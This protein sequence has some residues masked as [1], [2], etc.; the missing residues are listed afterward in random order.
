MLL[1]CFILICALALVLFINFISLKSN[2]AALLKDKNLL[3]NTKNECEKK[4]EEI[5][6]LY[7]SVKIENDEIKNRYAKVLDIDNEVEKQKERYK[8]V[9]QNVKEIEKL[10][11]DKYSIYKKLINEIEIYNDDLEMISV[12]LYKPVFN[13][14]TSGRYKI[15]LEENYQK[16][17]KLIKNNAAV[18]CSQRFEI[19]GSYQK[20]NK[21][22]QRYKKLMLKAFNGLCDSAISSLKWNNLKQIEARIEKAYK[23]VNSLGFENLMTI[24]QKFYNLKI[25]EM[26]LMYEF[27]QKKYEEKEE[28]RRLK[29]QIREEEKAQREFEKAKAQA[30]KEEAIYQKALEQAKIE[31]EST[32]EENREGLNKIIK[33]LQEK[34]EAVQSKQRVIS[35][36]QLTKSGNVYIISNIGSFGEN[37]YKI[38]MT[39]RLEPEERVN[40]LGDASVPF[41]FDIHAMI[42]SNDAPAL[43]SKLHELFK[44]RSVNKVNYRKE[45]FKVTLEEIEK[46]VKDFTQN[47]ILFTKI[48]E[49]REYRESLAMSNS[50]INQ[51]KSENSDLL[52]EKIT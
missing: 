36:A 4:L 39:R 38:G 24:E 31:L 35:Q 42:P 17:K 47:D 50:N 14:D 25:E 40:E 13:Y 41:K 27:E 23:D 52:P 7:N 1:C 37:I 28:Q 21:M 12:G 29:A 34:L 22:A 30:E 11:E 32:K 19:D 51:N 46:A 16:Q 2:S 44:D 33:D 26:Q 20:G 45:F 48:A 9:S 5:Q 18:Y 15:N 43:E 6:E 8:I 49:A 3:L 10:Y